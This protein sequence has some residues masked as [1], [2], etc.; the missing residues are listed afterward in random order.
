M[1]KIINRF[2]KLD[3]IDKFGVLFAIF[4][5]IPLLTVLTIDIIINGARM[6]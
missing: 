4:I 1:K 5:F 2:E 3:N 6:L